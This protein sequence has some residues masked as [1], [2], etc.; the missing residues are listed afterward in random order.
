MYN[1]DVVGYS[2]RDVTSGTMQ[3]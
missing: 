2:S 3:V 1:Y